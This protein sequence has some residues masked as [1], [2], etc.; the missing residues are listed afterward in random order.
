MPCWAL[1]QVH[2]SGRDHLRHLGCKLGRRGGRMSRTVMLPSREGCMPGRSTFTARDL[3][4]LGIAHDV[5]DLETE[6]GA[7]EMAREFGDHLR[8]EITHPGEVP[9]SRCSST[10]RPT[11]WS[12][13]A[14]TCSA[15]HG[16]SPRQCGRPRGFRARCGRHLPPC[17]LASSP[18]RW[19]SPRSSR[20]RRSSTGSTLLWSFLRSTRPPDRC[21]STGYSRRRSTSPSTSCSPRTSSRRG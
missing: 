9:R 20:R 8:D 10:R 5:L 21:A 1:S 17:P 15:P 18:R 4:R 7:A 3:D 12:P 2:I 19:A 14:D 13:S 6:S 11:R 16:T